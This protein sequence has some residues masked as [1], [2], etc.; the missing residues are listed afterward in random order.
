MS[1]GKRLSL[2]GGVLLNMVLVLTSTML[3][4]AIL[5]LVVVEVVFRTLMEIFILVLQGNNMI[6][7]VCALCDGLRLAEFYGLPISIVHSDSLA[8]VHSSKSNRC[9]SWKCTWWW[10]VAQS[11]LSK[12]S[13]PFVHAYKETNRVADALASYACDR[14][15]SSVFHSRSSLPSVCKGPI[16]IDKMGL[17]SIRLV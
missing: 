1:N 8:L 13:I 11:F 14:G 2:S 10:R 5:A 12:T 3:V 9:P 7:E 4:K 17:P 6:V 16:L 15:G